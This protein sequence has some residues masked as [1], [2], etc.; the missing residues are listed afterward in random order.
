MKLVRDSQRL[1][2]NKAGDLLWW[3]RDFFS[4]RHIL[5][6]H[7][8]EW[9]ISEVISYDIFTHLHK[10]RLFLEDTFFQKG[11]TSAKELANFYG[12]IGNL[13][14]LN[15]TFVQGSPS[16]L[17]FPLTYLIMRANGSIDPHLA[18][19]LSPFT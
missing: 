3:C 16:L 6:R 10:P 8:F 12:S 4:E 15:L 2:N 14:W 5:P 1:G 11:D 19:C 9:Q 17:P 13:S 7:N 18:Y